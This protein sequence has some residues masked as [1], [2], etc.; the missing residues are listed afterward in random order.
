M[1]SFVIPTDNSGELEEGE[2]PDFFIDTTPDAVI[3]IEDDE[4]QQ[5]I[6]NNGDDQPQQKGKN[7]KKS[8]KSKKKKK[9][10][11][12]DAVK[13]NEDGNGK[14]QEIK[15]SRRENVGQKETDQL[16]LER[17]KRKQ[18][19]KQQLLVSREERLRKR[20]KE[21]AL[22]Q[23]ME[24]L[25]QVE[26]PVVIASPLSVLPDNSC[27]PII[28]STFIPAS[29]DRSTNSS[30][31]V[32]S[33]SNSIDLIPSN[34]LSGY[35]MQNY[36]HRRNWDIRPTPHVVDRGKAY[37]QY[38]LDKSLQSNSEQ[39]EIPRFVI[40]DYH[41]DESND[42]SVQFIPRYSHFA[43]QS[44]NPSEGFW[45]LS[46]QPSLPFSVSL[47]SSSTTTTTT[48]YPSPSPAITDI[49]GSAYSPYYT[50]TSA[51]MVS[52]ANEYMSE[53]PE[54][55]HHYHQ[56]ILKYSKEKKKKKSKK[57]SKMTDQLSQSTMNTSNTSNTSN[58]SKIQNIS[59]SFKASKSYR[60]ASF[61]SE[62]ESSTDQT[63]VESEPSSLSRLRNLS[64][65]WR[66]EE[67]Q[68]RKTPQEEGELSIDKR[69][70]L[71]YQEHGVILSGMKVHSHHQYED[72]F[73]SIFTNDY[74]LV[75]SIKS[76]I[77]TLMYFI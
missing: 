36:P 35:F 10:R 13:E 26:L 61:S 23:Q 8:K 48:Q 33:L 66:R 7:G 70:E 40:N 14:K 22:R 63:D 12:E 34:S 39:Q 49:S 17:T 30:G 46:T 20:R 57:K 50:M 37:Y 43:D 77:S 65:Q 27:P 2:I 52:P 74:D 73:C 9:K 64:H 29:S 15:P 24:K 42:N 28:T 51:T 60:S 44:I 62:S 25:S 56:E 31:L 72:S 3:D 21:E 69:R 71:F 54:S 53:Y 19:F 11:K 47:S 41:Q 5:E 16:Q 32:F 1:L 59:Q 4:K 58:S 45:S 55:L 67:R 18:E 68:I 75:Q 76:S 38:F 6:G